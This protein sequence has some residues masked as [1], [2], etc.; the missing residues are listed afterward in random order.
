M[1]AHK[2]ASSLMDRQSDGP[3]VTLREFLRIRRFQ[4]ACQ[5][6][7]PDFLIELVYTTQFPPDLRQEFL[8]LTSEMV[9][10]SFHKTVP[11]V[12]DNRL[13]LM[14]SISLPLYAETANAAVNLSFTNEQMR[15]LSLVGVTVVAHPPITLFGEN[16]SGKTHFVRSLARIVGDP[17]GPYPSGSSQMLWLNPTQIRS[18][19]G[20]SIGCW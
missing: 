9:I 10:S 12:R 3:A 13:I 8:Q 18:S 11:F 19:Y 6:F 15:I 7:S 2:I 16:G 17:L 20:H 1:N 5:L 4:E 14:E